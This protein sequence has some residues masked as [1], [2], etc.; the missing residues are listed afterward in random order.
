MDDEIEDI[1]GDVRLTD[2]QKSVATTNAYS[3][4]FTDSSSDRNNSSGKDTYVIE[5]DSDDSDAV[6]QLHNKRSVINLNDRPSIANERNINPSKTTVHSN[7]KITTQ[8]RLTST[9]EQ[10]LRS[11]TTSVHRCYLV[12]QETFTQTSKT[13]FELAQTDNAQKTTDSKAIETQT[14][15]I[16]VIEDKT[17]EYRIE[18]SGSRTQ[19]SRNEISKDHKHRIGNTQLQI[20]NSGSSCGQKVEPLNLNQSSEEDERSMNNFNDDNSLGTLKIIDERTKDEMTAHKEMFDNTSE[21][22]DTSKF[23]SDF[24]AESLDD[25]YRDNRPDNQDDISMESVSKSVDN[26]VEELYNKL[27]KSLDLRTFERPET[28]DIPRH[29]TLTPLTEESN[30]VRVDSILDITPNKASISTQEETSSANKISSKHSEANVKIEPAETADEMDKNSGVKV[31]MLPQEESKPESFKLPPIHN[32]QSC[33]SSPHLNYLFGKSATL[34]GLYESQRAGDRWE[35]GTKD[36]ASGESAQINGRVEAVVLRTTEQCHLPSI[37]IE[38]HINYGDSNT[39]DSSRNPKSSVLSSDTPRETISIQERI[40]ELKM[41]KCRRQRMPNASL[42]EG[43]LC[44]AAERGCEMLCLTVIKNKPVRRAA[45][46]ALDDI[47]CGVESP[48]V[49]CAAAR[50]LVVCAALAGG[51]RDLLRARPPTA[52]AA[53]RHALRALA[54][55][56]DDKSIDTRKYAERLYS[57]LRPLVN[58]EAYYLTDVEVD[59]ASK[60]MKKYDQML[61]CGPPKETR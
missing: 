6:Y 41:S 54:A 42:G 23:D 53:R 60:Q 5:C 50:L 7:E 18:V 45:N 37:Y 4:D 40:K 25:E 28:F 21:F 48:L 29:V 49:R 26:D 52:A 14:S 9:R 3:Q 13:I 19:F 22:E 15:N 47:V 16:S 43:R 24:D 44:D 10:N 32:H 34:P 39:L 1:V 8:I 58:F 31:K 33:P 12:A 17:I 46:V 30:A 20:E 59:L 61:L 38:G 56:L 11:T 55:L 51:G 2:S 36:L 57:M 27:E 35:I